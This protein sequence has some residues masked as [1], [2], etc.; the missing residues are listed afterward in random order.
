MAARSRRVHLG[1]LLASLSVLSGARAEEPSAA[2]GAATLFREGREAMRTRS[3]ALACSRF[4]ESQRAAPALGTLLNL[5]V[6]EEARGHLALAL[7]LFNQVL[8]EAPEGDDRR[9]LVEAHVPELMRRVPSLTL[10]P[11]GC[12]PEGCELL[13][14]C[15]PIRLLHTK[16]SIPLDPGEHHLTVLVEGRAERELRLSFSEGEAAI[17][18]IAPGRSATRAEAHS[19][20][21]SSA[22]VSATHATG[23]SR[24]LPYVLGGVGAASLAA[25]LV[26]G[27]LAL[28]AWHTVER[29]CTATT[30]DSAEAVSANSRGRAL[31]IASTA[32]FAV[33]AVGVGAG[34]YLYFSGRA[35]AREG[36]PAETSIGLG[37]VRR[38]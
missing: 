11:D 30:C 34:A 17:Q 38:F 3:Y 24:T 8:R 32:S 10:V 26:T 18:R 15:A 14:D 27:L 4:E 9:P 21:V 36:Q 2:A 33:G 37:L 16:I 23:P 13:I 12:E 29:H 25:S 35:P 5:A 7:T 6:C 28:D 19:G 20:H 31:A 22:T 1:I